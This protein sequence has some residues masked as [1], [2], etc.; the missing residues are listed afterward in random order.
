MEANSIL[1]IIIC[2]YNDGKYIS[3][4]IKSV[5]EQTYTHWELFVMDDGSKDETQE[6]LSA[7]IQH[8][9]IH[10]YQHKSNKGK[11]ASLHTVLQ[12]IE[13]DWLIELD[14][15]DWLPSDSLW[16]ISNVIKDIEEGVDLVYG[17]Y[18]E[19]R[20][21]TRDGKLFMSG[22]KQTG[23]IL[24]WERYLQMPYPICP[25]IYKVLSLK[26]VMGWKMDDI[27]GGRLYEDIFIICQYLAS[28]KKLVHINETL[29]NRLLRKG[30]ISH[31]PKVNYLLWRKWAE[32]KLKNRMTD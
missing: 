1:A 6:I 13:T 20:E 9:N 25:R 30:S 18:L 7:F 11:A 31:Q 22:V 23:E 27:H 24:D 4:A 19:W 16:K 17:N 8:P 21:R 14:A 5:L 32:E 29:Y 26:Q 10:I 15:D 2:T 28:G 3:K 12:W